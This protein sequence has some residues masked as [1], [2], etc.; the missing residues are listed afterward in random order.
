M[1]WA[2]RQEQDL[3][4]S[5]ED[6]LTFHDF[7][8]KHLRNSILFYANPSTFRPHKISES[9]H[10]NCVF[11][12]PLS[13]MDFFWIRRVWWIRVDDWNRGEGGESK[14]GTLHRI[15]V[16]A[17]IKYSVSAYPDSCL[18]GLSMCTW[19]GIGGD[20]QQLRSLGNDN[21]GV[22]ENGKKAISWDWRFYIFL[23]CHYST[24]TWNSLNSP[25]MEDENTRHRYSL[26]F[27]ELRYSPLE[28]NSWKI[29]NIWQIK[30]G[31]I[32]DFFRRGC[33]RLLLYFNTN[34]PHSF[35]FLQNTSCIRKP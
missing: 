10:R 20:V 23:C 27:C 6:I 31:R 4:P 13:R 12:K 26:C 17:N 30:Q 8:P 15:R 7:F 2:Q 19:I 28:F 16:D 3:A 14:L 25:F 22:N 18:R 34:K 33:S 29:A 1:M 32:Q 35:F 9:A 24:T 5:D 21:G 11:L